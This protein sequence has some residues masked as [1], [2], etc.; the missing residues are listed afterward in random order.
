MLLE[1][2]TVDAYETFDNFKL[3]TTSKKAW[4]QSE[5]GSS[6]ADSPPSK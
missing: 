3:K 4:L 6:F 1:V 5:R 2:K